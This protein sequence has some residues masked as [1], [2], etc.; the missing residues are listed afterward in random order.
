MQESSFLGYGIARRESSTAGVTKSSQGIILPGK[1]F[2]LNSAGRG[3]FSMPSGL[4]ESFRLQ[5]GGQGK[6]GW[7]VCTSVRRGV[8]DPLGKSVLYV[9]LPAPWPPKGDVPCGGQ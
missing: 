1:L 3:A 7:A 4:L 5:L 9:L 6:T 2:S 8:Q